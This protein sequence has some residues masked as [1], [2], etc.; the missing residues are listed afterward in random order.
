MKK[1]R[2]LNLLSNLDLKL[3]TNLI[4]PKEIV[5]LWI[6]ASSKCGNL[7]DLMRDQN[8]LWKWWKSL[9]NKIENANVV[10]GLN[11]HKIGKI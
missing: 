4:R 11:V 9:K 8:G 3:V 6:E 10:G 5:L 2:P 7:E 1:S